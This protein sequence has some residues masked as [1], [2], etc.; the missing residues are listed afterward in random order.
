MP[1]NLEEFIPGERLPDIL[2]VYLSRDIL[3]TDYVCASRGLPTPQ[4]DRPLKFVRLYPPRT[5]IDKGMFNIPSRWI[6]M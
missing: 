1:P 6:Q 5:A 4:L 3:F 2:D